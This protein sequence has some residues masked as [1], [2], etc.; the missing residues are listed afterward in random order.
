MNFKEKIEKRLKSDVYTIIPKNDKKLKLKEEQSDINY[1]IEVSKS[2][3][4]EMIVIDL[5]ILKKEAKYLKNPPQDCDYIIVNYEQK[6]V[7]LI[8]LKKSSASSS[9]SKINEQLEAGL[10]WL[11][12]IFFIINCSEEGKED[13]YKVFKLCLRTTRRQN[14]R[15]YNEPNKY[16]VYNFNGN[17]LSITYSKWKNMGTYL[18]I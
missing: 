9:A 15:E 12:H 4:M 18:K 2:S 8:E 17:S 11:K 7:Y 5:S 16:G 10:K 14:M 1:E 6:I 13:D 3:N